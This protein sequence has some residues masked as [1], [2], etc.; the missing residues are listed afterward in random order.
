[1]AGGHA[2]NVEYG[3]AAL[4]MGVTRDLCA[5]IAAIRYEDLPAQ[6]VHEARLRCSWYGC[7][8][9]KAHHGGNSIDN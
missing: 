3:V 4:D 7:L 2:A 9:G 5:F 1:M 8:G 6:V